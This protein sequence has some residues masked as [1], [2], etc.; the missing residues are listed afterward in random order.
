MYIDTYTHIHKYTY[1]YM[2]MNIKCTYIKH[3]MLIF[4]HVT[5][6]LIK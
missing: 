5:I 2:R 4:R 6:K 3:S 1:A